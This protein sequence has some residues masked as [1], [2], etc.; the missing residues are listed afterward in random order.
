MSSE[1]VRALRNDAIEYRKEERAMNIGLIGLPN[2]GKTTIFNALTRSQAQVTGYA[3]TKMEPN[4]AILEVADDRVKNLSDMYQP[5]KT[6]YAS[7]ELMDFVG[8][9]Q[10]SAREGLFSSKSMGLI[11]NTDALAIVVGNF[12]EDLVESPAP[13]RDIEKIDDE[14]LIS[15]LIIAENR[16]ER[17]EKA[18]RRGKK[19]NLLELEEKLLLRIIEH[20]NSSQP[21][22]KMELE[23]ES[24]KMIRGFQFL[25]QKP[26]MVILNSD[27]GLFGKNQDLVKRIGERY[28]VIEFAGKFEMEL[29]QLNDPEDMELFMADMGIQESARDRLCYAAY[30]LLGYISFFTVGS[31]EVRAWS[32]HQGETAL[33]A[34]GTIHSDL[35]RGFIRAECIT[36]DDLLDCGSEKGVGEKGLLRLEGKKYIVQDGNI[37]NIRFNV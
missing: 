30:E 28:R 20:L 4:I 8:M 27:E 25:T 29:S 13:H 32:I 10:G 24:E 16:L 14:L 17:I 6:T 19:T 2:S 23:G 3:N 31:D 35:A 12:Q 34:A 11:K 26:V 5:Q 1:H 33:D 36:Y 37:L 7:I 15:D 22:R 18:Y 21:I 9:T